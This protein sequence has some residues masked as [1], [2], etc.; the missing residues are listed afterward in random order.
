MA[1]P[2]APGWVRRQDRGFPSS[3][4]VDGFMCQKRNNTKYL[5]SNVLEDPGRVQVL[6]QWKSQITFFLRN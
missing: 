1:G 4:K 2:A 3:L 6:A 5:K